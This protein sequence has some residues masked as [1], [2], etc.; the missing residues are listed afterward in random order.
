MRRPFGQFGEGSSNLRNILSGS[1]T[2]LLRFNLPTAKRPPTSM[3]APRTTRHPRLR[4]SHRL[5][6]L[7]QGCN[8]K[9]ASSPARAGAR[10]VALRDHAIGPPWPIEELL[11]GEADKITRKA[12]DLALSGD[13]VALR[14]CLDRLAPPR[15]DRPVPFAL[16]KLEAAADAVTASAALV[17]AVAS[18]DLTPSST[19]GPSL[20]ST[21]V[22]FWLAVSGRWR[23]GKGFE[24]S[25]ASCKAPLTLC[26]AS[27]IDHSGT[28]PVLCR[29]H[30][31][32]WWSQSGVEP[33]ISP[34]RERFPLSYS[35]KA[36]AGGYVAGPAC[37]DQCIACSL[38]T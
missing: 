22:R 21:T 37:L 32:Q 29:P 17:E 7:N 12:I 18:G 3:G 1:L 27:P 31:R 24:P 35:P 30:G 38:G 14:L 36:G 20:Y 23:R 19:R 8:R 25:D 10:P 15:R 33:P 5:S 4:S 13:T 26:R 2:R 9:H 34:S 28:S 16:P 6:L 11:D